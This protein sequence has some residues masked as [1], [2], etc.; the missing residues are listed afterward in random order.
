M[1]ETLPASNYDK[2]MIVNGE[3]MS[4]YKFSISPENHDVK[5][6]VYNRLLIDVPNT[7]ISTL[8]LFAIGGLMIFTGYEIIN[9]YR[10]RT[11]VS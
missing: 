7:G 1:I 3:L 6:D 9:I 11:L 4:V 8:N 10:K 2:E 5:I